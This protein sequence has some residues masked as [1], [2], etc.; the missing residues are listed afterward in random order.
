MKNIDLFKKWI[1]KLEFNFELNFEFYKNMQ[2]IDYSLTVQQIIITLTKLW[3][4]QSIKQ[5]I[6]LKQNHIII[7]EK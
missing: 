4:T 1:K 3:F 2:I 5:L 6:L 7:V